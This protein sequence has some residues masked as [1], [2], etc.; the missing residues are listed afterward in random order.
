MNKVTKKNYQ[1]SQRGIFITN[2]VSKAYDIVK[3]MQN[4]AGQSNRSNKQ[5][6]GK[7][8][9][10]TMDNIILVNAITE[11]QRKSHKNTYLFLADAEK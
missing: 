6:A 4:K 3:K 8:N 2:V 11:K 5:T 1:E 10:S 7:N 9:R